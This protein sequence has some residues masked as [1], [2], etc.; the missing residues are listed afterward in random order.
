MI[1]IDK[2]LSKKKT[3]NMDNMLS[4]LSSSNNFLTNTS[5]NNKTSFANMTFK[6][7]FN[8]PN[9][10]NQVKPMFGNTSVFGLKHSLQPATIQNQTAWKGFSIDKRQQLRI[11]NKDSDGDRVP[12]KYDCSINN[13][14]RQ[15]SY[16]T[17]Q[18][19]WYAGNKPPSQTLKDEG[20]V[21]GFSS[22]EYAQ[23]W[24]EKHNKTNVYKFVTDKY[25]LDDRSYNRPLPNK[26]LKMSDN[27]YIALDVNDEQIIED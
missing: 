6:K 20:R 12:D 24:K 9:M 4:N 5:L 7:P 21:F 1:S 25:M 18:V 26:K 8:F 19:L 3:K 11:S 2:I 27:E 10:N 17:P 23:G 22:P 16:N 13:A 14:M 15:D